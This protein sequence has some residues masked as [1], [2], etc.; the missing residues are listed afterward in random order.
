MF[1][2]LLNLDVKYDIYTKKT[3]VASNKEQ[4]EVT[5]C[6]PRNMKS[7]FKKQIEKRWEEEEEQQPWVGQYLTNQWHKEDLGKKL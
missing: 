2:N 7:V 6:Q 3:T 5:K 1:A 4:I